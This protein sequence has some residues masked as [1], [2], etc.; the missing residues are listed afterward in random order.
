[1]KNENLENAVE[2]TEIIVEEVSNKSN[3]AKV[4]IG[5]GVVGLVVA[6]VLYFRKK[7]NAKK[8]EIVVCEETVEEVVEDK[9]SSKK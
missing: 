1:M 3:I 6:G 8:D 2:S 7:R 9:K 5:V 4:A